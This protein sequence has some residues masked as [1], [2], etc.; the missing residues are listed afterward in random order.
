MFDNCCFC[1]PIRVGTI[2]LAVLC[3]FVAIG[4]AVGYLGK[5]EV[6]APDMSKGLTLVFG[7]AYIIMALV[8]FFGIVGSFFSAAGAVRIFATML[9]GFVLVNTVISIINIVNLTQNKQTAIDRCI[10]NG[11]SQV[12]STVSDINQSQSGTPVVSN[13][14]ENATSSA[15]GKV[16]ENLPGVCNNIETA[17]IIVFGVIAGVIILFEAYF[18][19]VA[20]R[21]A[22]QL[23]EN[24]FRKRDLRNIA[25]ENVVTVIERVTNVVT[26]YVPVTAKSLPFSQQEVARFTQIASNNKVPQNSLFVSSVE[27]PSK[28]LNIPSTPT[29]SAASIPTINFGTTKNIPATSIDTIKNIPATSIDTIKNIPATTSVDTIKN[30]QATSVDTIKI[31]STTPIETTT[32]IPIS[33]TANIPFTSIATNT[34]KATTLKPTTSIQMMTT[35]PV[36]IQMLTTPTTNSLPKT[37]L[38]NSA[39]SIANTVTSKVMSVSRTRS[40]YNQHPKPSTTAS[41][42]RPSSNTVRIE[43][44]FWSLLV[45]VAICIFVFGM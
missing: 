33:T 18:A 23:E 11:Q 30:I 13:I 31:I 45:A 12:N 39:P 19:R 14:A 4:A 2:I 38:T 9:W 1:I 42:S 7:I 22:E 29:I 44:M 34:V 16:A 21:F 24:Y 36:T 27:S 40:T 5:P 8:S 25:H 37:Q 10:Y 35:A 43:S 17:R 6:Y 3:L 41:V 15:Y 20:S 28:I 32:A 26:V